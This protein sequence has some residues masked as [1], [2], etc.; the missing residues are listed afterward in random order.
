MVTTIQDHYPGFD[1]DQ[2]HVGDSTNPVVVPEANIK[3]FQEYVSSTATSGDNRLRYTRLYLDGAAAGGEAL[4]AFTT[5][6]AACG[7]A[8]GAHISLNFAGTTTGELSGLGIAVRGTLHIPADAAWE[9]GTLA[10]LQAEIYSDGATSDSDGVTE[11][12][13]IRVINDGN[14][15]GIADVDDDANLLSIQGCTIASGNMIAAKSSA[16]VSHVARIKIGSTPYYIML[17]NAI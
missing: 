5:V 9:S 13:F 2:Y 10:A 8:H 1:K 17:S 15:S 11:L 3:F 6:R 14:A 7:T 12:S 16:A 4:R